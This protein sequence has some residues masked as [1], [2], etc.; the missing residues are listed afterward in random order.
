MIPQRGLR[1]FFGY[2]GSKWR[3]A[4]KYY[5][6]PKHDTI[7]E[8]FAGSA[9]Y[10]L[11]YYTKNVVLCDIDPII[12]G[13]WEYLIHVKAHEILAIPDIPNDGHVDDLDI[14]EEARWLVGFWL[15]ASAAPCKTPSKWMRD[16]GRSGSFWGDRVRKTIASQVS[17]IRH[18]KVYN[19]R[20]EDCPVEW[21]ATWFVDPPY[22]GAGKYYRF[23][24]KGLDYQS[25]G[26]WCRQRNGQVIVCEN[27]G[28]T[29]LPFQEIGSIRSAKNGYY[30][31]ESCWINQQGTKD[32]LRQLSL[33]QSDGAGNDG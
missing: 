30:S 25:L 21:P 26:T 16:S 2:Y 20:Y 27:T 9:G 7:V 23:G 19:R 24:S 15:N 11:R 6:Y 10:A 18:W 31:A 5:P 1:R 13:V 29:W 28:A 22:Q 3:A 14:C 17:E 32:T 33:F 8:P 4:R 12:A